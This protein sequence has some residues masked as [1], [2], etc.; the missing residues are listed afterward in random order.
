[1][2]SRR[3]PN[4]PL[5]AAYRIDDSNHRRTTLEAPDLPIEA[6]RTYRF[7]WVYSV[8]G[9]ITSGILTNAPTIG[10]KVLKAADWHLALPTGLSGLGLLITLILGFWMARRRKMPFVLLPGFISCAVCL[11][12]IVSPRSLWFL[13]F[14]GLFNLFETITRPAITAIIRANYP[15]ATRGLVTGRLRQWSAGLFLASA[16]GTAQVLDRSGSWAVIQVILLTAA[17]LQ[18]GAYIAFSFIRVQP[19]SADIDEEASEQDLWTFAQSTSVTLRQ[20]SR[21]L[22]YLSGCFL[23]GVSAL[24]YDPIVRAYFSNEFGFN[25]TQCVLLVDFLPSACSVLTVGYLGAWFDRTNPLVAWT[26]IRAA[27][28][29]DPLL[30]ALAPSYPAGSLPIAL[31]ARISRGSVMNGSWV[32]GWQLATN[33]FARRRELTSVYM[34]CYLT[35]TGV[36]RLIGPP[37]GA[38][39]LGVFSRREV[40]F[41]GGFFVMLSSLHAWRQAASERID[42]RYP[43]FADKESNV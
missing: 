43:T 20:D 30:L 42:G 4:E 26:F 19:E 9:G 15:V 10:I 7:H 41:I 16:L 37:L 28:G 14:L 24:T 6:R 34:G 17:T 35:V 11:G 3:T 25:Y 33:Y 21:F 2:R 39:L 38:L 40:L 31:A 1:V 13:F 23:H 29:L 12:M 27:W 5:S 22:R 8:L 36:Q 18:V 32:L